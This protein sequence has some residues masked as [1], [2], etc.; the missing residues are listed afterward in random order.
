MGRF[1]AP[2]NLSWAET[3]SLSN[4][5]DMEFQIWY[6]KTHAPSVE[7]FGSVR[8]QMPAAELMT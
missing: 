1:N 4:I 5:R 2:H 8:L 3:V 6:N 7:P